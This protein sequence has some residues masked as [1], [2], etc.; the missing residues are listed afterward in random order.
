[1]GC[2][3]LAGND[4]RNNNARPKASGAK[5]GFLSDSLRILAEC[6]GQQARVIRIVVESGSLVVRYC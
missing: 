3:V 6:P 2:K 4:L 1:M 5:N